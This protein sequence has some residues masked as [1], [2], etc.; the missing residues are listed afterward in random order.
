MRRAAP[1]ALAALAACAT[2]GGGRP[3]AGARPDLVAV[4]R[5]LTRIDAAER[6]GDAEEAVRLAQA[7]E[8]ASGDV[9][10]Q[11]LAAS[12]QPPGERRW[13]SFRDISRLFPRSALPYVGMARTYLAWRTWDQ[14]EKAI[15]AALAREGDNWLAV[16]VRAE[17][18]EARGRPADAAADYEA[19]L[20]AD[21]ANPEAHLGLAR[22]ARA[23]GDAERAHAEAAAALEA[24]RAIPGAYAILADLSLEL[25]E[26]AAAIDFWKGAIEAAPRDRAARVT[27]AKL[28]LAQGDPAGA[29]DQWKAAVAIREDPDALAALAEAARAAGDAEGEQRALERLSLLRPSAAEWRRIAEIRAGSNDLAGA[30]RAYLRALESAPRDAELSLGLGRVLLARGDSQGAVRALRSAGEPGQADLAA[31]SRRLNLE[32]ISRPDVAGVQRATLALVQRTFLSRRAEVPSLSG[33]LRV[34]V[35]V[36]ASGAATLVEVLEDSVH[37]A[38][39]R[40]TAFW[41][42]SDATYPQDRPGRYSFTFALRR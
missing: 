19:V 15:A 3:A 38:D 30:E 14:A 4:S 31:L 18:A 5:A 33:A 24:S 23:R 40:A 25:G 29:R 20:A 12:A 32:R 34:R 35:T 42:L 37:D 11:F 13:N 21:P 17:L 10:A 36:D 9:V 2:A 41:N 6:Q 8:L 7:A 22:L 27:L 1:L 28:L 26:P 39:V 16:R